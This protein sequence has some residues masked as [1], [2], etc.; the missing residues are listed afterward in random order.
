MCFNIFNPF[1][2]LFTSRKVKENQIT[3][4]KLQEKS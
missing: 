4:Q 1:E 2:K 3:Y